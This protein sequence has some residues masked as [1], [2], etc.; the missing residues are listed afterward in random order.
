VTCYSRPTE[1]RTAVLRICSPAN[2]RS[3]STTAV[4]TRDLLSAPNN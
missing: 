1:R 4:N 3:I 2:Q